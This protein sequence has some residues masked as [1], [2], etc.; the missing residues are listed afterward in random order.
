MRIFYFLLWEL[1]CFLK[2]FLHALKFLSYLQFISIYES[3][4]II[5]IAILAIIIQ[6]TEVF[7]FKVFFIYIFCYLI[8]WYLLVF[9]YSYVYKYICM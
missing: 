8:K 1:L 4:I 7:R 3:S 5:Y 2:V 9:F 6:E